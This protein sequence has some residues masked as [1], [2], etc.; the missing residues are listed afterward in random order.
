MLPCSLRIK[1]SKEINQRNSL[2]TLSKKGRSEDAPWNFSSSDR[3]SPDSLTVTLGINECIDPHFPITPT[4]ISTHR[5][6]PFHMRRS[7]FLFVD[8]DEKRISSVSTNGSKIKISGGGFG[9][10]IIPCAWRVFQKEEKVSWDFVILNTKAK[11]ENFPIV[12]K[13]KATLYPDQLNKI[14][15]GKH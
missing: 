14:F 13:T 11:W 10:S 9:I 4:V 3:M 12:L 1:I 15:M 6:F 8:C 7:A 5:L 2:G